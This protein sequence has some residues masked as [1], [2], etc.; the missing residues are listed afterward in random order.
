M[1]LIQLPP[2]EGI[3]MPF[4]DGRQPEAQLALARARRGQR[5][6]SD[7]IG[8]CVVVGELLAAGFARVLS[9]DDVLGEA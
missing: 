3:L 9:T 6:G 4:T 8:F 5:D 2:S 1:Y 7:A